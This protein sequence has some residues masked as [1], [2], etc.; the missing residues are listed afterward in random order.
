L[1]NSHQE[2]IEKLMS[3]GPYALLNKEKSELLSIGLECLVEHHMD[4]N[5]QYRN[6]LKVMDY[7]S[8]EGFNISDLP[9][10]P[11]RIFKELSLFTNPENGT[12]KTLTSSG[13]SGQLTSKIFI[14]SETAALQ[15]KTLVKIVGSYIGTQRLPMLIV[16]SPNTVD[17]RNVFSARAAGILGFTKFSK[18]ISYALNSDMSPNWP[19][20]EEFV[21]TN[22]D[23]ESV[24]FGFTSII[25]I[26]LIGE[27][28]KNNT[29]YDLQNAKL[30]HGG[31]WKKLLETN[32][33]DGKEFKEEIRKSLGITHIHD[34]YGMAE[35]TGS[36]LVECELGYMHTSIF[37]DLI[38][39]N[40]L[41]YSVCK[42][43][44]IG[45]IESVSILPKSYPGHLL[46]T[47]DLGQQIGVD[48]CK[49]GRLGSYFL[50]IGRIKSAELR[51][52]SDTYQNA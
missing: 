2:V 39:R 11:V 34:Y 5:L 31:G 52:C 38:I 47:E 24:V 33:V 42:I 21:L 27:M 15:V 17:D 9:M 45:L 37:S 28:R 49:C 51:G 46:L 35:Q 10:L 8:R 16:D 20:I 30:F 48:D 4:N 36:I 3:L 41:D 29:K 18:R 26:H 22:K 43:G 19:A 14:D 23:N 7:S 44:E 32:Q 25:W 50:I 12:L 40:P 13:T 6:I 1:K